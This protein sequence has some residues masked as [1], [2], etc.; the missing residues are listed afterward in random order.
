LTTAKEQNISQVKFYYGMPTPY[1]E[2]IS[3]SLPSTCAR[4]FDDEGEREIPKFCTETYMKN[5]GNV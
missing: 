2:S 4:H 3:L 5:N 1:A